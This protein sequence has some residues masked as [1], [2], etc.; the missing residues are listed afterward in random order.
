MF[1]KK[2][3]EKDETISHTQMIFLNCLLGGS[4]N[5]IAFPAISAS[6]GNLLEMKIN[7]QASASPNRQLSRQF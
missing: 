5:V 2:K 6:P 3:K 4:Q 1:K 7:S